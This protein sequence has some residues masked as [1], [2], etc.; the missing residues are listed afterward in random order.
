MTPTHTKLEPK[1]WNIEDY[2]DLVLRR[3]WYILAVFA[4]VFSLVVVYSLTRPN[5]YRATTTFSLEQDEDMGLGSS[6]PYYY[7]YNQSKPI[8]YYQAMIGSGRYREKIVTAAAEDSVLQSI[9]VYN[10]DML[11]SAM[12]SIGISKEEYSDLM[13]MSVQALDPVVAYRVADI[14]ANAFKDRSREIQEEKAQNTI[15]YVYAQVSLAENN[16]EQAER[17]LQ[18][19][20]ART[21]FTVSG[22]N[23]G[24]LQRLNEIENKITEIETQRQLAQA[25]LNVYNERLAEY[26]KANDVPGVFESSSPEAEQLRRDI[27]DLESQK[28]TLVENR[29][30]RLQISRLDQE[31]AEKKQL[32]RRAILNSQVSSPMDAPR[33]EGEDAEI[34]VY[35]QRKI[36]EELTLYSLKNQERFYRNL[37][38]NYRKQHPN[39][40]EHA[41]ELAR[42]QRAKTVNETMYNFLIQKGE[43]AKIKAATGTGGVKIIAAP[44]IP[45]SPIPQKTMRNI[46]FGVIFG[47]GLG[48]GLAFVLDF[49]DRSIHMPEEIERQLQINVIG[50]IPNIDRAAAKSKR[51]PAAPVMMDKRNGTNG[52]AKE[53]NERTLQLLPFL[54]AKNP[55][56]EAYRNLRTD[57]QFVNVDHQICRLIITSSAPGEGKSI[58]TANLAISFAELGKRVLVVDCDLRKSM[59]HEIFK[60]H[61]KPG[62]SDFLAKSLELPDIIQASMFNNLDVIAA[63]TS[64]PNPAEMLGSQ[65][66]AQLIERVCDDY[67][68]VI[69]DT[70]PL[71][72]VSDARV[73]APLVKNVLLVVRAG[74]TKVHIARDAVARL[75]K[76][77]AHTV[78]AVINGV[79]S[80]KGYDYYRY[81]YYYNYDYYYSDNG[82]KKKKSKKKPY[83]KPQ[84][85]KSR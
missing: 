35:R 7:Y 63:G 28:Y 58:T 30:S 33:P 43:E 12:G 85:F 15:E 27:D 29:G 45:N 56:N 64:P 38:N 59:Q 46:L 36:D 32:L 55:L 17:D 4:V 62:I 79:G 6:R 25:N 78:G 75:Q 19:F 9:D 23:D 39:M 22:E 5:V 51:R 16:L 18:E 10:Q 44:G 76:V 1:E 34:S 48:V 31:I 77:D 84:L 66:M 80:K 40:L 54:G 21:K 47:L 67:D 83:T 57:L 42:L 14:A 82:E 61:K 37:R 2:L 68:L 71:I 26:Q 24:I 20:K 70:P 81:N 69:F 74:Q 13:F 49:F 53:I 8:E 41:I 50:T 52:E 72:A 65:K 60:L 73:L 11:Y 3:I